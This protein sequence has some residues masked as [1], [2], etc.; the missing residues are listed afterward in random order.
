MSAEM[1]YTDVLLIK[2]EKGKENSVAFGNR[3]TVLLKSNEMWRAGNSMKLI[4]DPKSSCRQMVCTRSPQQVSKDS[5][6]WWMV[7]MQLREVGKLVV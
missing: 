2:K 5:I 7:T 6:L 1:T 3:W 4:L